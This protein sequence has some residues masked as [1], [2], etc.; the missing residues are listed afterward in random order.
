VKVFLDSSVIL[1]G[2]KSSS[3]ASNLLLSLSQKRKIQ[4]L[5][6]YLVLEEVKRNISKK[7]SEKEL[8]KLSN[9][10][11]NAKP[12]IVTLSES[13]IFLYK[14]VVATKDVHVL[15]GAHKVNAEFLATLDKK[16]LL[17]IRKNRRLPFKI[18]T[19]G[20]LIN[21]L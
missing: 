17:K 15:G 10:L 21:L 4:A 20:E 1:A 14:E 18:L 3:G 5:T 9:W 11:K 12:K 16:H 7:F 8:I 13:D 19:P 2:L 6:S